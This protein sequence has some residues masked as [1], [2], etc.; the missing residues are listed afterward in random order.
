MLTKLGKLLRPSSVAII[1]ASSN[2]KKVGYAALRNMK[3]CGF[4]GKLFAVNPKAEKYGFEL[5]G[6][7]CYT[8]ISEIPDQVDL[9]VVCIPARFIPSL[10]EEIGKRG[11]PY[12]AVIT[13]GFKETGSEGAKME[14]QIVDI[15]RK[16]N[17]R[18]VGPNILGIIDTITPI[19][20]S[21]AD[22][23]P[24]KGNI[25][26]LS[27]SGALLTGIL[28]WS[29]AEGIGFSSFISIGNKADLDETDFIDALADDGH[30]YAILAYL[31]SINRGEKFIEVCKKV[32]RKKPV[33]VLKS[34]RSKA[35]AKAASSHTGSMVGADTSYNVAFEKCGVI[36]ADSAQ[37]LFDMAFVFS[38]MPI[39]QGNRF[40][41]ITNAG[42]PGILA[43]DAAEKAGL[44]LVTISENLESKL[45]EFLPAASSFGNPIDALGTAQ[46]EDYGKI[47]EIAFQEENID[48]VIVIL[49]PQAMTE[50]QETAEK[51]VELHDRYPEKPIIA[52]FIGGE[53]LGPPIH[54][55][56]RHRIPCFPLPERGVEA[57]GALAHYSSIKNRPVEEEIKAI[58]ANRE[59]VRQIFDNVK[60]EGRTTLL[61]TEAK[62]VVEAYDINVP[63]TKL[64]HSADEAAEFAE[65]V[66]FPTVIKITGE[67]ILHKSDIGGVK[68]M[69]KSK[70]EARKAFEEIME[71]TKK[72]YPDAKKLVEVQYMVPLGRELITGV[73]Q[74]PQFGPMVMIGL[75]GIYTNFMK[76]AAFGL[77]P[78]TFEEA[79]KVLQQTKTYILLKGVRGEAPS[80]IDAVLDTLVKISH[81]AEDFRQDIDEMDINPFFVYEEGKGISAVDV[82]ITLK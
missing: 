81:L 39:P 74:D 53:E 55:L 1:G 7:K 6:I 72:H 11:I 38:C 77:A 30:T 35:G 9:A 36:R 19:N 43:T 46:A 34:G 41:I 2:E 22:Q 62:N 50:G 75:G 24:I 40:V 70:D 37:E 58:D 20:A 78:I 80:D 8:T 14:H 71:N 54:Y 3:D 51:I 52:I 31:E 66:G 82:K 27:Q 13:A 4:K 69:I 16:Y 73:L 45:R 56:K 42:G 57:M 12:V 28:D 10:I 67:G 48:G 32:T 68:L 60:K 76:D 65:E 26:F 63:P 64:A 33:L 49:T 17:I 18:I 15:A 44:E 25:A 59:K 21:F 61:G 47:I 79:R 5:L 23:T 29:R